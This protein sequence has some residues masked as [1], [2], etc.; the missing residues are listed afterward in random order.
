MKVFFL[1][2]FS[3]LMV[4]NLAI[5]QD[6]TNFKNTN[7]IRERAAAACL[8]EA[9]QLLAEYLKEYDVGIKGELKS[10]K[11]GSFVAPALM[12]PGKL[13][14]PQSCL[15]KAAVGNVGAVKSSRFEGFPRLDTTVANII[16]ENEMLVKFEEQFYDARG[17]LHRIIKGFVL[18]MPTANLA[19]G[20][21]LL[22]DHVFAVTGTQQFKTGGA[23]RTFLVLEA[24]DGAWL[25]AEVAKRMPRSTMERIRKAIAD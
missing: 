8:Q 1:N 20:K 16:N 3:A 11:D 5:A 6:A 9:D 22:L 23:P 2:L 24:V 14:L 15:E 12:V 4:V 19:D 7:D 17:E 25:K 21:K 18:K 13:P 10:I